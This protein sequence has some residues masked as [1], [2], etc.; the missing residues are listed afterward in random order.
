MSISP[1]LTTSI[2]VDRCTVQNNVP[3]FIQ[4]V[5]EKISLHIFLTFAYGLI[6]PPDI[7]TI[8]S[9]KEIFF[10]DM[11]SEISRVFNSKNHGLSNTHNLLLY[12]SGQVTAAELAQCIVYECLSTSL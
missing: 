3:I 4:L 11:A 2:N 9:K 5:Y 12:N 8:K 1:T 6:K 7:L 10:G